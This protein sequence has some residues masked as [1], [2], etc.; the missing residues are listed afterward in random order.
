MRDRTCAYCGELIKGRWIEL[1][2]SDIAEKKSS[3]KKVDLHPQ[4]FE[5]IWSKC[6][7]IREGNE[8]GEKVVIE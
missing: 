1:S 2:V 8:V 4:C 6:K 3:M 7:F 5:E